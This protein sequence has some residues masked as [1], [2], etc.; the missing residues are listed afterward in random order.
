MESPNMYELR[1]ASSTK[2]DVHQAIKNIDHYFDNSSLFCNILPNSLSNYN[3]IIKHADGVGTK[4]SLAYIYWKETGDSSVFKNLAIDSLVMNLDDILCVGAIDSPIFLSNII[5]RN[6]HLIDGDILKLI[7]DGFVDY[8]QVLKDYD[9]EILM[10]GGETADLGDIVK[11]LTIDTTVTCGLDQSDLIDTSEISPGDTIIGFSSYGQ[12]ELETEYNSGIGSN[13]L[14]A[15]RHDC[16]NKH[17]AEKYPESY[18]SKIP[19]ELAYSGIGDIADHI[20][21]SSLTLGQSLLSPTRIYMPMIKECIYKIKQ[22]LDD[23]IQFIHG[24]IHCTGGGQTKCL[25]YGNNI[26]Y[27]K[28]NLFDI[29][30]IFKYITN[31]NSERNKINIKDMFSVYNMGHRLEM[32]VDSEYSDLIDLVINTAKSFNIDAQIIGHCDSDELGNFLEI[33]HD[34]HHFF[35][36]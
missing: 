22:E 6:K 32:I 1:G 12:S 16:L 36:K 19:R 5:N 13:G 14:T 33:V 30:P 25:K 35:Y 26:K 4:A 11:T 9:I 31:T 10:S 21:K 15:A 3:F 20:P 2:E 28:D 23:Y 17:Y 8:I 18:D 27:I 7:I 34:N 24:I 29:P